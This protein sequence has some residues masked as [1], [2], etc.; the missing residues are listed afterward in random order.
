MNALAQVY[1]LQQKELAQKAAAQQAARAKY[2]REIAAFQNSGLPDMFRQFATMPLRTEV[3]QRTYQKDFQ[4]LAWSDQNPGNNPKMKD[5]S[6]R[7]LHGNNGPRWFVDESL[8]TGRM[9][10]CY[11]SGRSGCHTECFDTP[12]GPW[13]NEF[14]EYAAKA[15][16]PTAIADELQKPREPVDPQTPQ[17][18]KLIAT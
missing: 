6:L 8:D 13:L 15:C 5:V 16:D 7:C 12:A 11:S 17:R 10:Y 3:Q 2:Q 9:R 14:I 4:S 18:R 1:A